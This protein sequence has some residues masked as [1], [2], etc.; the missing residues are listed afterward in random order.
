MINDSQARIMKRITDFNGI[1]PVEASRIALE[2]KDDP[3][4][5]E[6]RCK[7]MADL[8]LLEISQSNGHQYFSATK[9][10]REVLEDLHQCVCGRSFDSERGLNRHKASCPE[11]KDDQDESPQEAP[12]QVEP[13]PVLERPLAEASGDHSLVRIGHLLEIA[14]E[15]HEDLGCR[16][17]LHIDLQDLSVS[18]LR[19][20]TS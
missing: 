2:L 3:T 13:D 14:K 1:G 6:A 10:G 20:A 5:V 11:L 17:D 9:H 18:Y 7:A 15:L 19:E 4:I 16:I 12:L 8:G